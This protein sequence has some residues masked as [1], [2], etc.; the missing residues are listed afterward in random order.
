MDILNRKV[1]L[2]KELIQLKKDHEDTKKQEE[3]LEDIRIID[4]F[5]STH[6]IQ[7]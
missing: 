6:R 4:E 7:K 2:K 3:L 1:E 5:L